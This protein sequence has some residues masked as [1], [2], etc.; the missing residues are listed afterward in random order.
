MTKE[1]ESHVM[2]RLFLEIASSTSDISVGDAL[3]IRRKECGLNRRNFSL[4]LGMRES[5]YS[6]VVNGK[7]RLSLNATKRAYAIGVPAAI[8]LQ[9]SE[10]SK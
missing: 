10:Q 7:K 3:E 6:E 2:S 1:N 8:L 9:Q 5:H 4:L